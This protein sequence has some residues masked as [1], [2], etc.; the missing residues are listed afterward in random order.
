MAICD[1]KQAGGA[2]LRRNDCAICI[3]NLNM[4]EPVLCEIVRNPEILISYQHKAFDIGRK[5][6]LKE[7]ISRALY[8]D[9]CE[10]IKKGE[11][12]D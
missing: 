2:Y 12:Y 5:N 10:V 8:Q 6:H 1:E 4:I 7:S 11:D 3:N 9:F